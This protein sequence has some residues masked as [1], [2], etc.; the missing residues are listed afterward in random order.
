MKTKMK[1]EYIEYAEQELQKNN[2]INTDIGK[3]I[4]QLIET[5]L[6][7]G[8]GNAFMLFHISDM[9]DRLTKKLPLL[10]LEENEMVDTPVLNSPSQLR[11]SRYFPVFKSGDGKYYDDQA[12]AYI[13]PHGGYTYFYGNSEYNSTKEIQFPYYPKP[14]YVY[15]SDDNLNEQLS[16]TMAS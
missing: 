2:L 12:I 16:K 10:P 1:N 7:F 4:M 15:I 6:K 5:S 11:H 13:T 3:L 9:L 8:D 14:Q